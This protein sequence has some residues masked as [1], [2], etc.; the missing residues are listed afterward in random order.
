MSEV[1][2]ATPKAPTMLEALIPI[3]ALVIMLARQLCI[4]W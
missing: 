4:L 1:N 3:I 2:A